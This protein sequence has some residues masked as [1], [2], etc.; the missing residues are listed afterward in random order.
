MKSTTVLLLT[1]AVLWTSAV[2]A[3][4]QYNFFESELNLPVIFDTSQAD[5]SWRIG[6]PDK[7]LFSAAHTEPNAL[8]T[9]LDAPYR[10]GDSSS[11]T[12]VFDMNSWWAF[13]YFMVTWY[14]KMDVD[15]GLDGGLIEASYDRGQ[16]WVNVLDDT[17]Y[18]VMLVGDIT[19][20]SL[21][22]GMSGLSE[23][24][25]RFWARAGLCW[26]SSIGPRVDTVMLR[27][28][29]VSDSLDT[30]KEG[31]MIDNMEGQ[32]SLIDAVD[33]RRALLSGKLGLYPNPAA[34]RVWIQTVLSF[35]RVEIIDRGGSLLGQWWGQ[36]EVLELEGLPPGLYFL[37]F[38]SGTELVAAEKILL[39]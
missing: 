13:P 17:V 26:S 36:Q 11:F 30:G 34:D 10:A 31:W 12:L 27:F 33:D 39:H 21:H 22:N 24:T 35:D 18:Q 3:Q 37:R 38:Y 7:T 16:S 23:S 4:R 19:K 1:L 28:T 5:N 6:V 2:T 32:G 14:H 8:L 9:L 20:G 15:D 25:G 29:F